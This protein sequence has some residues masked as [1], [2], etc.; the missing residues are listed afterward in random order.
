MLTLYTQNRGTILDTQLTMVNEDGT[1]LGYMDDV[2]NVLDTNEDT[3]KTVYAYEFSPK[4]YNYISQ[5]AGR[6][7]IKNLEHY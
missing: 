6:M 4:T 5:N 3:L 7:E 2:I 1:Y